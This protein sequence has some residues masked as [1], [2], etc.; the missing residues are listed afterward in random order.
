MAEKPTCTAAGPGSI[1][2]IVP[3]A[4]GV[5]ERYPGLPQSKPIQENWQLIRWFDVIER[6]LLAK[7]PLLLILDDI[8]GSTG[9]RCS[10]SS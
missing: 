3:N 1:G 7:Q 8:N 4:A 5:F 10:C 6:M 9:R 2:G